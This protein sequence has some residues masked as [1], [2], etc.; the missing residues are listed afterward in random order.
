MATL[1]VWTILCIGTSEER[2]YINVLNPRVIGEIW[3]AFF[4]FDNILQ[5]ILYMSCLSNQ[6]QA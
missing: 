3:R 1:V 6:R 2:K 5:H 4:R